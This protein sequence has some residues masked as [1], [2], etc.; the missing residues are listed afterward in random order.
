[1][2]GGVGPWQAGDNPHFYPLPDGRTLWLLNDSFINPADPRGPIT[3]ASTFVHN[4]A[5]I[6][7]G[8]CLTLVNPVEAG[9]R[10]AP[11]LADPAPGRWYWPLGG[12]VEGGRLVVFFADM[13]APLP[14]TWGL[15]MSTVGVVAA[16]FDPRTLALLSL[17][18]APDAGPSPAYGYSMASDGAWT[19]LFAN[20]IVYGHA[21][22]ANYVARGARWSIADGAPTSTGRAPAGRPGAP[23]PTRSTTPAGTARCSRCSTSA[24]GGWRW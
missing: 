6:Q 23:T 17:G 8:A 3:G 11:F 22:T 16:V 20:N 2:D 9:G 12:T 18:P 19:Y 10:P 24:S 4:A 13:T 1:M 14:L 15:T 7:D 5:F 21:T